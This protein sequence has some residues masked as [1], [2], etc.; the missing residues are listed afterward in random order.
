NIEGVRAASLAYFG[1]E[2]ARLTPAEAALLV[3]LPQAPEARRPD[4]HPQAAQAARDR[5]LERMAA[6][7]VLEAETVAAA[8]RE[9]VPR[10]RRDFPMLAPHLTAAARAAHPDQA[11]QRLT[12]ERGLQARLERLARER[13]SGRAAKLSIA[14]LV[15]DHKSGA[16][17]ASVGSAGLFESERRG[18]VDMTRAL[19]SPGSTLKPLIYGL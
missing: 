7:G 1:K 9:T 3:A 16:I 8:E 2:P 18:Y 10:A 4:R 14:I 13:L 12:I 19:R 6:A 11:V 17:L 15:A 5:V